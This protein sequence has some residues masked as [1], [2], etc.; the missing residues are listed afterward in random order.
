MMDSISYCTSKRSFNWTNNEEGRAGALP[1]RCEAWKSDVYIHA[2]LGTDS[3][4]RI[5]PSVPEES[6]LESGPSVTP[7]AVHYMSTHKLR[8]GEGVSRS[9]P[10]TPLAVKSQ[11]EGRFEGSPPSPTKA[12]L[13]F[14]TR[15]VK[16]HLE[17]QISLFSVAD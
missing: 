8:R 13:F 5:C 9:Y 2:W 10:I 7:T 15:R 16:A 3:G 14:Y 17:G 6:Y 11:T 4:G 1:A 12:Q